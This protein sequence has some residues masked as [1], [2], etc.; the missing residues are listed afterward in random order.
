VALL[1]VPVARPPGLIFEPLLS[2]PAVLAMPVDHAL[3][4]R[5]AEGEAVPLGALN[6]E[7]LILVRRPGAPGLYANLLALLVQQR[8]Q[9]RV[10]A[11][12]DRMMTNLN[13]VASGAGLTVVPASMQGVHPHSITYRQL[14]PGCGLEVPLT[15][16]YRRDDEQAVT[17]T[18][19][20][21]ARRIAGAPAATDSAAPQTATA[22]VT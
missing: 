5:Y 15:L 18:L 6:G 16:G 20:A 8:A 12:V 2:E 21:L 9:V 17:A 1:R 10:V 13:L 4:S 7:P 11:E 14:P 19:L 3:A 22:A